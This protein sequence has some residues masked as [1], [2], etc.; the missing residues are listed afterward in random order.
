MVTV[1]EWWTDLTLPF[2]PGQTH[3]RIGSTT[4]DKDMA[5]ALS[6]VDARDVM[7]RLDAICSPAGWQCSYSHAGT[8]TIC[9]LKIFCPRGES[10]EDNL[11]KAHWEW[12]SKADGAGDTDVE[13]DKGAMSA[14]FKRAAV[15][16]GVGRYIYGLP[17]PWVE[18]EPKGRSFRIKKQEYEKLDAQLLKT[19]GTI[20]NGSRMEQSL[21]RLI[22]QQIQ[23]LT[24]KEQIE[25]WYIENKSMINGLN[26]PL[27]QQIIECCSARKNGLQKG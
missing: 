19:I 25:G 9:D 21:M 16:F 2:S 12:I 3:W 26:K 6:Y 1:N 11:S 18:I 8:K 14:A 22:L 5:L 20:M 24:T 10:E 27:Q 13:A 15:R 23:R 4:P 7:D 17:S